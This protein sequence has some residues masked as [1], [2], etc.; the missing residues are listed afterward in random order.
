MCDDPSLHH[1]CSSFYTG[2]CQAYTVHVNIWTARI[3]NHCK[4]L[5]LASQPPPQNETL[6][7]LADLLHSDGGV[8]AGLFCP[9]SRAR[10][11]STLGDS[12][13]FTSCLSPTF[14]SQPSDTPGLWQLHRRGGVTGG[15]GEED[16]G[17]FRNR[18]GLRMAG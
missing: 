5:T 17:R 4:Y 12:E 3:G 8:G 10:A 13:H 1:S 16:L 11:T 14:H 9:H 18:G 7:L 2:H 15:E 6:S